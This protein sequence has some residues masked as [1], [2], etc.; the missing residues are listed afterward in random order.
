MIGVSYISKHLRFDV[1]AVALA[2]LLMTGS[3]L[4]AQRPQGQRGQQN[5]PPNTAADPPPLAI[6]DSPTAD[7]EAAQQNTPVKPDESYTMLAQPSIASRMGLTDQQI[8]Q[9]QS[10]INERA[11]K[12][13]NAPQDQW[14]TIRA[15]NEEKLKAVLTEE[16]QAN[17]LKVIREKT[18]VIIFKD[19]KWD[20][21]LT[22]FADR[23]GLQLIMDAPPPSTFSFSDRTEYSPAEA[24]DILN[25]IL[26]SKGYTLVRYDN[27]LILFNLRR[28]PQIP[29]V[30][31]PKLQ[32]SDLE[33]R[34]ARFEY[35]AVTYQLG[36]RDRETVDTLIKPFLAANPQVTNLPGNAFMLIDTV[37]S[38]KLIAKIIDG[39]PQPEP[40]PQAERAQDPLPQPPTRWQVYVVEKTDPAKMEEIIKEFCGVSST[41]RMPNSPQLHVLANDD[42]HRN[43]REIIDRLEVDPG[44]ALKPTVQVYS[45]D[46]LADA[47]PERLW[48]WY[49]TMGTYANLFDVN[50]TFVEKFLEMV[51]EVVPNVVLTYESNNRK[52]VVLGVPDDH[53]IISDMIEQLKRPFAAADAPVIKIYKMKGIASS[54][55]ENVVENVQKLVPK[56]LIDFN[57]ADSCLLVV[58]TKEEHQLITDAITELESMSPGDI[59]RKMVCYP[60]NYS[61]LYR[62]NMLW[63]QLRQQPEFRGVFELSEGRDNQ[64]TIWATTEQHARVRQVL[65]ELL[66]QGD[67]ME[68]DDDAIESGGG[69][70][71]GTSKSRLKLETKSFVVRRGDVYSLSSILPQVIPGISVIPEGSSST[72]IV[73][74][75]VEALESVKD[76]IDKVDGEFGVSVRVFPLDEPP[77]E[78][79]L[80]ALR[81][82]FRRRPDGSAPFGRF[83]GVPPIDLAGNVIFDRKNMRLIAYGTKA[84]LAQLERIMEA[85]KGTTPI[86]PKSM[87]TLPVVQDLPDQ[88]VDFVRDAVPHADIQYNKENRMVTVAGTKAE[89]L[90]ASKVLLEAEA[91]LPPPERIRLFP[92]GRLITDDL[93]NLVKSNVNYTREVKRDDLDPMSLY[94][95]ARPAVLDEVSRF[96]EDVKDQL[97]AKPVSMLVSYPVTQAERS[98]FEAVQND[99][100]KEI[101][102]YRLLNDERRNV[103]SIW[104]LPLQHE[105][106]DETLK[107]LKTVAMPETAEKII[108]HS[109]RFTES[110]TLQQL[111]KD[112]YPDIN[113]TA[114]SATNRLIIRVPSQIAKEVETL[115]AQIDSADP[116]RVKRYFA[117]YPIGRINMYDINGNYYNFYHLI[118][119]LQPLVPNAKLTYDFVGASIVV[120]GTDD[121]HQIIKET[122]ENIHNTKPDEHFGRFPLRRAEPTQLM[123]IIQTMFPGVP[124][125]YDQ[126]GKTLVV[127]SVN[128]EQL[129]L[130]GALIKKLD[131]E[132]PG[133]NDPEVRFYQLSAPA[134]EVLISFLHSLTPEASIV[135]D[136]VNRQLMVLARPAEHDLIRHNVDLIVSTF[137]PDEPVLFLYTVTDDQ[138]KR[139]ETYVQT[140]NEEMTGLAIRIV[141]DTHPGQMSILAKPLGHQLINNALMLFSAQTDSDY[142]LKLSIFSLTAV[143]SET[144]QKALV[145]LVPE[146]KVIVDDKGM[147]LLVLAAKSELSKVEQIFDSLDPT[148]TK[149]LKYMPYPVALGDPETVLESIKQVYPN[150]KSQVDERN[151]RLL[152]W[153][154][155]EEHSAIA[156]MI[157]QTNKDTE[158]T[159]QERFRSYPV[160][161]LSPLSVKDMIETLFPG[162]E[163]Y[164]GGFTSSIYGMTEST[165]VTIRASTREHSQ[166]KTLLAQMQS[167]DDEYH[168]EFAVYPM[169]DIDPLTLEALMQGMFPNAESLTSYEIKNLLQDDPLREYY[170]Q[171]PYARMFSRMWGEPPQ[172]RQ[173]RQ[174]EAM[175]GRRD[176]FYKVDP[177]T[178]TVMVFLPE[179]DQKK[180]ASMMESVTKF[181]E[182][183]GKL[184][185][186]RYDLDRGSLYIYIPVIQEIVPTAKITEGWGS[187]IMVYASEE[188]HK[189]IAQYVDEMNAFSRP[190]SQWSYHVLTIPDG[191]NI[192]RDLI[193]RQL[194]NRFNAGIQNGP[195][196]NQI[197]YWGRNN[198]IPRVKQFFDELTAEQAETEKASAQI[199]TLKYISVA[200]AI[201]WLKPIVPNA[202]YEV[203]GTMSPEYAELMW[204]SKIYGLDFP[205]PQQ[206]PDDPTARMMTIIAMPLDHKLIAE[207]LEVLDVDLPEEIKPVPR[208][209]SFVNYP[210]PMMTL[211]WEA[212]S[213]AF[214]PPKASFVMNGERI[215]IQATATPSV[216]K[217]IEGFIKNYVEQKQEE[218]PVMEVYLMK[219]FNAYRA[220]S[221]FQTL[222][223]F[224]YRVQALPG[225]TPDQILIYARPIDHIK[226]VEFLTKLETMTLPENL[227]QLKIYQMT[228]PNA[229]YMAFQVLRNQ[230]PAGIVFPNLENNTVVVFGTEEDQKIA[231]AITASVGE[232]YPEHLTK[233]FFVKHIPISTAFNYLK[234]HFAYR[235]VVLDVDAVTGDLIAHAA[236]Q[237][238]E[239]IQKSIDVIDVPRP[240]EAE[241]IGIVY[242]FS[243][244]FP[245]Y[246]PW[247]LRGMQVVSP[248]AEI[249]PTIE[250]GR[251]LAYATPAEHVKIQK[252]VDDMVAKYAE[253]TPVPH[254][255][256]IKYMQAT[257]AWNY[258]LVQIAPTATPGFVQLDPH[259]LTVLATPAQHEK[260]AEA[261]D[262]LNENDTN[263]SVSQMYRLERITLSQAWTML[264][265]RFP[266][267]NFIPDWETN[268]IVVS[269]A[270][271]EEQEKIA[272]MVAA[273]DTTDDETHNYDIKFMP[274]P[275]AW[276]QILSHIAPT[277]IPTFSSVDPHKITILASSATHER[278]DEVINK[279]NEN[280]AV[281]SVAQLYRLN[282]ISNAMV[283]PYLRTR[284]PDIYFTPDWLSNSVIVTA[285]SREEQDK[286]AEMVAEIDTPDSVAENYSLNGIFARAAWFSIL[287]KISIS[288]VPGFNTNDPYKITV[289]ATPAAQKA[290]KDVI[291]K[292]NEDKSHVLEAKMYRLQRVRYATVNQILLSRFPGMICYFDD[293]SNSVFMYAT[294]EEHEIIA[295]M[296]AEMDRF[297][298]ET[299]VTVKIHN[300]NML[301]ANQLAN[302]LRW[303]YNDNFYGMTGQ[304]FDAIT[305]TSR[306]NL[307]VTAS[308]QMHEQVD[309]LISQLAQGRLND[310]TV[311]LEVYELEK[312]NM[313]TIYNTLTNFFYAEGLPFYPAMD[314]MTSK[315]M[316]M[317]TPSEHAAINKIIDTFRVEEREVVLFALREMDPLTVIT[318][319]G[320]LFF[321][322]SYSK[323]PVV[324]PD[325]YSDLLYIHATKAQL[326]RIREVLAQFGETG[327]LEPMVT[328]VS[329]PPRIPGG[330]QT[331]RLPTV[332]QPPP[333]VVT[334]SGTMRVLEGDKNALLEQIQ[335]LSPQ[336]NPD[337]PIKVVPP[338]GGTRGEGLG[339]RDEGLGVRDEGREAREQKEPEKPS[340][341]STSGFFAPQG[342]TGTDGPCMQETAAG[343]AV[344]ETNGVTGSNGP[345]AAGNAVSETNGVTGSNGSQTFELELDEQLLSRVTV[346]PQWDAIAYVSYADPVSPMQEVPSLVAS[347]ELRVTS[348]METVPD[349]E[350]V[351]PQDMSVYVIVNDDGTVSLVSNDTD[352]LDRLTAA[353]ATP[354]IRQQPQSRVDET[355]NF[356][357]ILYEDREYSEFSVRHLSP[358]IMQ[359]RLQMRMNSR[360]PNRP[361]ANTMQQ[362]Y[363]RGGRVPMGGVGMGGYGTAGYATSGRPPQPTL[364]PQEDTNSIIVIGSRRDRDIVRELIEQLDV[365][366]PI[367][368]PKRVI[369]KNSD[370]SKVFQQL[371][372]TYGH[373]LDTVR[374]PN[375]MKPDLGCDPLTNSIWIMGPPELVEMLSKYIEETDVQLQENPPRKITVKQLGINGVVLQKMIQDLFQGQSQMNNN[376]YLL[377]P[378]FSGGYTGGYT[379]GYNT[380]GYG[381]TGY[382]N[383]GRSPY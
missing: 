159:L 268:N 331:D 252:V 308:A 175:S 51:K 244:M 334:G 18:I 291:D 142:E 177:G 5:R 368:E 124:I 322:E 112:I 337:N 38:Q 47:P 165:S 191:L 27:L 171:N 163:V 293:L 44:V 15:E 34:K 26:Q 255:Y 354:V 237:V 58:G 367:Y 221:L 358:T 220:M 343:N 131:P 332:T 135:P 316:V 56:A 17:W 96:L 333:P 353:L 11:Q 39:I 185:I 67:E 86:E 69:T 2:L 1:I 250:F 55:I 275:A 317:A 195:L 272:E 299:Q 352:A 136:G 265:T 93:I 327:V 116:N 229:V 70:M 369:V 347:G 315:M 329:Y 139:I 261:I 89:Q 128:G 144:V 33:N 148:R 52:L 169:G 79:L 151:K 65:K 371:R 218:R 20:E 298:P 92:I 259:K 312:L 219:N 208:M 172:T 364:L 356:N 167:T 182:A 360:F 355:A 297:D 87:L 280:D 7:G 71:S 9:V 166:I 156:E 122:I 339:T 301:S 14:D 345:M 296:V 310:P 223:P 203:Q 198:D 262:M 253:T 68:D 176:G 12:L 383:Y 263:A 314:Y 81:M 125:Y 210:P 127:Q 319:V 108:M 246:Y 31:L 295:E 188:D 152:I 278:L 154:T 84:E 40:R 162:V 365:A 201:K 19:Q 25:S 381:T 3:H 23:L 78:E 336:I 239:E 251:F 150:I 8:V 75:T 344:S 61:L 186:K 157:E 231:A 88:L 179:D 194:Y 183:S 276:Y 205:M 187:E 349:G 226:V 76:F 101:G 35:V 106:I 232:S 57:S 141:D 196:P 214:P 98:R 117:N 240:P 90:L 97:A 309:S 236:P 372:A 189:I 284:F 37:A 181:A 91:S 306:R 178:R 348:D 207:A 114:D 287:S 192:P 29:P 190:G 137:T 103:L 213:D 118:Q 342:M 211:S 247:A 50:A 133:P 105:R 60:V 323:R 104:A 80:N 359:Q 241:K 266:N 335:K 199:Y 94:V 230:L 113:I 321:E 63:R 290:I 341:T 362:G 173:Q 74:G 161:K 375:N 82:P 212:L 46:Q 160:P 138:R 143:D 340:T 140:A 286:I 351:V 311:T 228:S 43:V 271:Q 21:V 357:R 313:F 180:I 302:A 325:Y 303:F 304:Y 120:W 147:R 267:A 53:K 224:R 206:E 328:P 4:S 260:L 269:A 379:G 294:P 146:A 22:W 233:V 215:A 149:N 102:E 32:P 374:L 289:W 377:Y 378:G 164:S 109:L 380:G 270:S 324:Q 279:L 256:E 346:L 184:S 54:F 382:P 41:V 257:W 158:V 235:G 245:D 197:V 49:R 202:Q 318:L 115:L 123:G 119:Q 59:E 363:G 285:A 366:D 85:L 28:T 330:G 292:L 130:V 216:H 288:A 193:I 95:K 204:L 66:G 6:P 258:F 376:S 373:Y 73:Y 305:D 242:D 254:N 300:T 225:A 64:L 227:T 234:G 77:P 248:T 126:N 129:K 222:E 209:Y 107:S 45:L 238:L 134:T 111:V 121:E 307:I 282:Y 277:A 338:A 83:G 217:E 24:L 36:R 42:Q 16:Q 370:A 30:Y 168:A 249:L 153:A 350:S 326:K 200:N 13:A 170:R 99:L 174:Y 155:P 320:Q 264:R 48:M 283:L 132:E 72:I 273:I 243:E 145:D 361:Q 100:K 274:A 110:D 10:A 62:W 281:A